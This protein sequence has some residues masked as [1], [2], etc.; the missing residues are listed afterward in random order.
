MLQL[1]EEAAVPRSGVAVERRHHRSRWNDE[2]GVDE[3]GSD[4]KRA[5]ENKDESWDSAGRTADARRKERQ[6]AQARVPTLSRRK[7]LKPDIE[8]QMTR[9]FQDAER[10][11][12]AN[13]SCNIVRKSR[14]VPL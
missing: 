12:C 6:H 3:E 7:A 10:R 1:N 9:F 14:K 2:G 8:N 5:E 11:Q 13:L 4:I